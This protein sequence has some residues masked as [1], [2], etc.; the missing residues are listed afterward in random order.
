LDGTLG[1]QVD[2]IVSLLAEWDDVNQ[3]VQLFER[4]Q[5]LEEARS[6]KLAGDIRD[7]AIE[8]ANGHGRHVEALKLT[9]ALLQT[10]PELEAVAEKLKEDEATLEDLVADQARQARLSPLET[11]CKAAKS[12]H[13]A[14]ARSLAR[15]G[16][17]ARDKSVLADIVFAVNN[18]MLGTPEDRRVAGLM[19]RDLALFLNNEK[20][21]PETAFRLL[22]GLIAATERKLPADLLEMLRKDRSVLHRN[23]K[24]PELARNKGNFAQTVKIIDEMLP[25]ADPDDRRQLLSLKRNVETQRQRWSVKRWLIAAGIGAFVIFGVLEEQG[26]NSPRPASNAVAPRSFSTSTPAPRPQAAPVAFA[27]SIPPVGRDHV[28]N[29]AQIRYC[30]FQDARLEYLR[31]MNMTNAQISRFNAMI[32]DYNARCG[33]FQYRPGVLQRVQAEV[34]GRASTLQADARRNFATW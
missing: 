15:H 4:E 20:D 33:S 32:G 13:L 16:F 8:L 31:P 26:G 9:R 24:F 30:V 12:Q 3:P 7:L 10:F 1:A 6:K 23:W 22:D 27:E 5:G 28:L 21:A 34:P 14:L 17:T 18:A 29:E 2:R 19:M 11:A 25:F